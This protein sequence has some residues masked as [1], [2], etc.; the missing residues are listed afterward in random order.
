[1]SL[2]VQDAVFGTI[3]A[4]GEGYWSGE[5]EYQGRIVE[6]D[7]NAEDQDSLTASLVHSLTEQLT[8][9]AE[10]DHRVRKAVLDAGINDDDALPRYRAMHLDEI[11]DAQLCDALG[12]DG[13]WRNDIRAF[14]DKLHIVRVGLYPEASENA[15]I[16]DLTLS[17]DLTDYLLAVSLD[18]N[19]TPTTIS[20]ES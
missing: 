5:L 12:S 15:F 16:V 11:E 2:P 13:A 17:R 6:V 9:I 18:R 14:L 19:G 4:N 20:L 10:L 1:M 8:K 3:S 7:L